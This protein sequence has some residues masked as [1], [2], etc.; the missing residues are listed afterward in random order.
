M[1]TAAS[2]EQRPDLQ[3]TPPTCAGFTAYTGETCRKELLDSEECLAVKTTQDPTIE[4]EEE[5]VIYIHSSINQTE[6]EQTVA[7]LARAISLLDLSPKCEQVSRQQLC[8]HLFGCGVVSAGA[9]TKHP[10]LVVSGGGTMCSTELEAMIWTQCS[11][12]NATPC[13]TD[14]EAMI[15]TQCSDEN[16]TPCSKELEAAARAQ[17]LGKSVTPCPTELEAAVRVLRVEWCNQTTVICKSEEKDT[18]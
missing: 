17:C 13:S 6:V 14:L 10:C 4:E 15:W 12:E 11:H 16:A 7:D 8:A 18:V 9:R 5:E 1:A 2:A 3:E